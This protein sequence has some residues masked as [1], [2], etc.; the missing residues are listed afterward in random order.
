M[1]SLTYKTSKE[2]TKQNTFI[3]ASCIIF[4]NTWMWVS[5]T[6]NKQHFE[7]KAKKNYELDSERRWSRSTPQS[8]TVIITSS[9]V[10]FY[11]ITLH[12]CDAVLCQMIVLDYMWK[13]LLFLFLVF[14]LFCSEDVYQRPLQYNSG[15]TDSSGTSSYSSNIFRIFLSRSQV[16]LNIIL[17]QFLRST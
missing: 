4:L 11:S 14:F 16:Y 15:N 3:L 7:Q 17:S 5:F 8:L 12:S 9:L 2:K 6:R 13:Y 10:I 1:N